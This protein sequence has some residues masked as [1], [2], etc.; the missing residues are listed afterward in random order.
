VLFLNYFVFPSNVYVYVTLEDTTLGNIKLSLIKINTFNQYNCLIIGLRVGKIFSLIF[1]QELNGFRN[2][3]LKIKLRLRLSQHYCVE[4]LHLK[5]YSQKFTTPLLCL[6]C[7]LLAIHVV[8]KWALNFPF[9]FSKN[10]K[11]SYKQICER[12]RTPL[13]SKED[14]RKFWQ[15]DRQM[16]AINEARWLTQMFRILFEYNTDCRPFLI[17]LVIV[18]YH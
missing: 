14:L 6:V 3:V 18:C 10:T 1:S 4:I 15:S 7:K 5:K 11:C 13:I 16:R 17:L 8:L 9:I 2:N 12:L